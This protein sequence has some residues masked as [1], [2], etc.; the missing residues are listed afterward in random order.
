MSDPEDFSKLFDECLKDPT[1]LQ[2]FRK[3]LASNFC[4][5]NLDFYFECK[6][7]QKLSSNEQIAAKAQ[8]LWTTYIKPGARTELNVDSWQVQQIKDRLESPTIDMFDEISDSTFRMLKEDS[9]RKF[10]NTEVYQEYLGLYFFFFNEKTVSISSSSSFLLIMYFFFFL[11][12]SKGK[13]F[14]KTSSVTKRNL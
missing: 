9:F 1:L 13:H 4:E 2:M 3:F 5:E 12:F 10:Y 14:K 8:L 6:E 11:F 7:L